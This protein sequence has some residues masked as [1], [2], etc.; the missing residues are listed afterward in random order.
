M[1]Q[2]KQRMKRRERQT[3]LQGKRIIVC[4]EWVDK[5]RNVICSLPAKHH[6]KNS[7]NPPTHSA[8]AITEE[9]DIVI[10]YRIGEEE[11]KWQRVPE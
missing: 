3:V 10:G 8:L 11:P 2:S 6:P 4:G 1:P 7:P 9:G 5:A